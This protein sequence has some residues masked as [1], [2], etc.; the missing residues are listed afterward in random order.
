MLYFVEVDKY[1]FVNIVQAL[2]DIDGVVIHES[3]AFQD[4]VHTLL[5][6]VINLLQGLQDLTL[7]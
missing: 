6:K 7:F 1:L 5:D 3:D 4:L 2:A